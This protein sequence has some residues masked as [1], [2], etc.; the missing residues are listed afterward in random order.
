[1]KAL[2]RIAFVERAIAWCV[3]GWIRMTYRA[4]RWTLIDER[5]IADLVAA[6]RPFIACFWHGRLA[7]WPMFL[8]RHDFPVAMLISPHGDGQIIISAIARMGIPTI[9]GST[10]RDP[11]KALVDLVAALKGGTCVAITPD[12]PR[13]PRMHLAVGVI[14][15]AQ[16]SGA[17]IVPLTYSLSRGITMRGSWDHFLFPLPFGRGVARAGAPI[18]VPERLTRETREAMRKLV[19]TRLNDL[20]RECDIACGRTPVEPA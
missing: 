13:G 4:T 3:A 17:P 10:F 15:A 12:G 1:M 7:P 18:E 5:H 19:E 8:R 20:T 6:K 9:E 14:A 11:M 16:H 2:L